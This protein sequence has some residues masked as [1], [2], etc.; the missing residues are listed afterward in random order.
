MLE[1][2]EEALPEAD[3]LSPLTMLPTAPEAPASGEERVTEDVSNDTLLIFVILTV[4]GSG[5]E[6]ETS[7]AGSV[8]PTVYVF[9]PTPPG[10]VMLKAGEVMRPCPTSSV[11]PPVVGL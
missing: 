11:E 9:P 7:K 6:V 1:V 3:I 4:V 8:E 2:E 5:G 10:H